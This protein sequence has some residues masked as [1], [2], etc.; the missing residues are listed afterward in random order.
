MLAAL[1]D[2]APVVLDSVDT[3]ADGIAVRCV[4][5]LTLEHVAALVDQ[6]VTVDDEEISRA[7]LT[8]LERC[9]A[10]VEPAGAV[11]LAALMAG[12][13]AG[14]GTAVVLLSGGNV[15]P[16]LLTRLIEHGLSAAGR[17]FMIRVVLSDRPGSL[18]SLTSAIGKL[19]LNLVTVDHRR[20]GAP[21]GVNEVEVFL[22]VETR[23]PH[24]RD[25]I[26]PSLRELGFRAEAWG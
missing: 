16:L 21:I 13:V 24:H 22:T 5:A 20:F 8:L 25:E 7:V 11:G 3:L 6:I 17:Y 18:G 14:K 1:D 9:K 19:G 26:V 23:G 2:R 10:V 12:K 4:S 15:D